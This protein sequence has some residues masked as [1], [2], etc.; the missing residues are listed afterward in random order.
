MDLW[1]DPSAMSVTEGRMRTN[2]APLV[3][4]KGDLLVEIHVMSGTLRN[5]MRLTGSLLAWFVEYTCGTCV[6]RPL[7]AGAQSK[8]PFIFPSSSTS[9]WSM[10][11]AFA[12]LT[13]VHAVLPQPCCGKA[14]QS[15]RSGQDV[16]GPPLNITEEQIR[17]GLEIVNGVFHSK[18]E[19][20]PFRQHLPAGVNVCNGA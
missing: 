13:C 19:T 14:E 10:P 3:G 1:P 8:P 18:L 17:G 12:T 5:G 2:L 15:R 11:T 7:R 16:I 4:R 9:S 20:E 6:A